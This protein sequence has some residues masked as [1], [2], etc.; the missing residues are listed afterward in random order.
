MMITG[1]IGL[2]EMKLRQWKDRDE[3]ERIQERK[4]AELVAHAAKEVPAYRGISVKGLDGLD[5]LPFVRREQLQ[6]DPSMFIR[7]DARKGSLI[8]LKTSGSSGMPIEYCLDDH[9]AALRGAAITHAYTEAGL[10]LLD[11]V[12]FVTYDVGRQKP[13]SLF[14][15][16]LLSMYEGAESTLE[17]LRRLKP[18]L[19]RSYPSVLMLLAKKNLEHGQR[20]AVPK[21]FSGSEVL[22]PHGRDLMKESFG[23]DIRDFYGS[24]ETGR[25]AWE[26][27]E[28][29]MHV[30]SDS[31]IAEVV[32][33]SG[34]PLPRG[35]LGN[36]VLTPL[37]QRA[38]PLI[39]YMIGDLAALGEGC[40]C[41]RGYHVIKRIEGRRA[42]SLRMKSGYVC[43]TLPLDIH[44][45]H[46]S[47]I[48]IF[49]ARQ[50]RPGEL[51]ISIVPKGRFDDADAKAITDKLSN[52]YLE[53]LDI[54]IRVVDDVPRG[55]TGKARPTE[56]QIKDREV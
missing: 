14:S 21:I 42:A 23:S 28:G 46:F 40:P 16:R 43:N 25:I 47:K 50:E 34:R 51:E 4:L 15:Y 27:E 48:L 8:T 18:S 6:D 45:R 55:R 33:D 52:C 41:G 11:R 12:A 53:P 22:P 7:R 20:L 36:L 56:S 44:L 19:L 5:S 1:A 31:V 26:C 10:G 37:N 32:D 2:A 39:R 3:L 35:R 49:H 17:S 38:M 30:L 24:V 29:S 54:I 9:D 13:S